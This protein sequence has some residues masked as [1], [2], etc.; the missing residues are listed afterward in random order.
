MRAK[1]KVI[2][3]EMDE[4]RKQL[5]KDRYIKYGLA[6]N[7]EATLDIPVVVLRVMRKI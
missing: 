7:S 5:F 1:R 3:N 2:R 6:R 4:I